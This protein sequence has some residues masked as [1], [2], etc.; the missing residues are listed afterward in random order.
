MARLDSA[1]AGAHNVEVMAK[2]VIQAFAEFR[3]RL[4]PTEQQKQDAKTKH[5]GVKAVLNSEL[6]VESAFLSGSYARSTMI[7]PP[8]DIDLFVVLDHEKHQ[9]DYFYAFDSQTAILDR[10]HSILKA[11]YP[12][13]PIRK[14][15]P[16]VHLDFTTYG[17]DVVPAFHRQGGGYMIL[18][19]NRAGWI[20]TDPTKHAERATLYNKLTGNFFIPCAKMLKAWNR[21]K[22]YGR[23]SGFQLE[24]ECGYAW[25][26]DTVGTEKIV[27]KVP[28]Y[29]AGV[30]GLLNGL[31]YSLV[32]RTPD[33]AELSGYIDDYLTDD[34]R[35][36]TRERLAS[37]AA[38][39]AQ[40]LEHEK[41][42]RMAWAIDRWRDALGDNFPAYG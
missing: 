14:D 10:F 1:V 19:R 25:P 12:T 2:T 5:T 13:T 39:A 11:G 35:K 28:S 22:N 38:S 4:E 33:P 9:A 26:R 30:Y 36:W 6:W 23:L 34:A 31:H 8:S 18:G 16:A 7:R 42:G 3:E 20:A 27:R 24:V 29:A 32:T 41:H 17:F 21:D 37:S 15:H 40:A